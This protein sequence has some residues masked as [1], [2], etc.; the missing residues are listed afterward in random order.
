MT[1]HFE[2]V[3]YLFLVPAIC[4]FGIVGNVLT[5]VVL[6]GGQFSGGAFVYLKGLSIFDLLGLI[7]ILPI[8]LVR[9][10][11]CDLENDYAL[12]FYGAYVYI[13]I[14]DI[15]LKASVWTTMLLTIERCLVI[16]FRKQLHVSSRKSRFPVFAL[17]GIFIFT[18]VENIPTI[19]AFSI[20]KTDGSVTLTD[21]GKSAGYE[22]YSWFDALLFQFA[23]FPVLF[24]FNII[25]A[26]YLIQ[27]RE[28]SKRLK[29]SI[30]HSYLEYRFTAE[31]RT[32]LMLT[33]I[34][35]LFLVTMVPC[36]VMQLVGI[37]LD[38]GSDLYTHFQMAVTVLVSL[39]FS[40]NFLL[41]CLL[42]QRFWHVLK[43]LLCPCCLMQNRV[44]PANVVPI[45]T[46]RSSGLRQSN[47]TLHSGSRVGAQH[48]KDEV[49]VQIPR[50]IE[51]GN[52][53][54]SR[55]GKDT[56]MN[57]DPEWALTTRRLS[58]PEVGAKVAAADEREDSAPLGLQTV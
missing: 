56:I 31:R 58:A 49:S 15:F 48:R 1:L 6:I 35:G 14:G 46:K 27:H 5:L 47:G 13:C 33:G 11:V 42:N 52:S 26:V 28:V 16:V 7:F 55:H 25:L 45:S 29:A 20:D 10:P 41:Y 34:V 24:I 53:D 51:E 21:Y 38:Y 17:V 44:K 4:I 39:N 37:D 54:S 8:C 30:P 57:E 23:P 3:T 22:M 32:L 50:E 40:C 18:T 19:Y 2:I 9:C 12:N 43:S 36:S